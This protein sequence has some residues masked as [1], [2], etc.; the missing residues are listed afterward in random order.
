MPLSFRKIKSSIFPERLPVFAAA[1]THHVTDE[2]A[3]QAPYRAL[4]SSKTFSD[5]DVPTDHSGSSAS[6]EVA[7]FRTPNVFDKITKLAG[8]RITFLSILIMILIWLVLGLVFGMGDT[9]QIVFQNAS[10]IQVYVTD[11]LLIRQQQNA[12]RALM[13]TI[14]ELQSRGKTFVRLFPHIPESKY[15]NTSLEET[16]QINSHVK[17]FNE[18]YNESEHIDTAKPSRYDYVWIKS[19]QAVAKVLGS[20]WAYI[21]YWIGIGVWIALGPSFK[22]SNTWQLYVNTATALVLTFTSVFL[23]NIQQSQEDKL[24]K[25]LEQAIKIDIVIEQNLRALTGDQRLNPIFTI[26]V[27][28]RSVIERLIDGFADIMG[29]GVGVIISLLFTAVWVGVGPKLKFDDNWWLIIGTFT[30][31]V[32]FIDGFVLRSLYYGEEVN[33]KIQFQD[34]AEADS[35]VLQ[36][37][38]IPYTPLE[39]PKK[40]RAESISLIISDICGH[41]YASIG[42]VGVVIGLLVAASAMLWSETAQLLCNTPTMIVEGF[43]LLVLIQAHNHTNDERKSDFGGLLKRKLLLQEFIQTLD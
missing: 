23:Q 6:H 35:A 34:L 21:L 18:K 9:W 36:R 10:S 4:N 17:D 33:T 31:L 25:L 20:V 29:S 39:K 30:G 37:L 1:K 15:I 5:K 12:S 28:T 41:R 40:G 42:S 2:V 24:A 22:F 19:C 38:N 11:I 27:P 32:G 13:G 14:A 43:L 16:Q 8:S 26:P 7:S 3:R